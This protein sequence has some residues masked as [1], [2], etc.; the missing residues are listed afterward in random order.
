[1]RGRAVAGV[2]DM[3]GFAM[4]RPGRQKAC[5]RCGELKPAHGFS[6]DRRNADGLQGHCKA[7]IAKAMREYRRLQPEVVA[8]QKRAFRVRHAER[9]KREAAAARA[10]PEYKRAAAVRNRRWLQRNAPK[11]RE[12]VRAYEAR[13]IGATPRWANQEKIDAIYREAERLSQLTGIPHQV[14]HVVPLRHPLVCGLHIESNL[15]I[16]TACAN[17]AKRNR[18]W[19][20]MLECQKGFAP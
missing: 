18:W 13:K 7:C 12:K 2:H 5:I 14:D 3:V 10:T 6:P 16:M 20:G 4:R 19:P 1:M 9:L 11:N 17:A 15:Q 8:A